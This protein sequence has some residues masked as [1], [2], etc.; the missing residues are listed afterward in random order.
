MISNTMTIL[1][2]CLGVLCL[3]GLIRALRSPVRLLYPS[4]V[5]PTIFFV[6]YG[7]HPLYLRLANNAS[8]YP[9][10][11]ISAVDLE[12]G[13]MFAVASL[14]CFWLPVVAYHSNRFFS[15]IRATRVL[16]CKFGRI[17]NRPGHSL[18][19]AGPINF[20][21]W[22]LVLFFGQLAAFLVFVYAFDGF[23]A[24][25]YAF[26][27]S[28]QAGWT[29]RR[30]G[31]AQHAVAVVCNGVFL[32]G[33]VSA[34]LL[35][36]FEL[37]Q[38][39]K[40]NSLLQASILP[41]LLPRIALLSRGMFLPVV[42]F[43][44]FSILMRGSLDRRRSLALAISIVLLFSG[45][46]LAISRRHITRG[47]LLALRSLPDRY[48]SHEGNTL[49][50]VLY[51][52]SANKTIGWSFEYGHNVT[53]TEG[54]RDCLVLLCPVP[55][56]LI[57]LPF[58]N[59]NEHVG[60]A[61]AGVGIPMPLLG[62]LYIRLGWWGVLFLIPV[63]VA[64]ALIEKGLDSRAA[65]PCARSV[66]TLLYGA[67]LIGGIISLH[68]GIRASTRPLIWVGSAILLVK[69]VLHKQWLPRSSVH[70]LRRAR[71]R[72]RTS[73]RRVGTSLVKPQEYR[74]TDRYLHIH[75]KGRDEKRCCDPVED[76]LGSEETTCG[77]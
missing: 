71:A 33:P 27:D 62:E 67:V 23:R 63:G 14:I 25:L 19:A 51:A 59:L 61:H 37:R 52:M 4:I 50:V 3:P 29:G 6:G 34:G 38:G 35:H 58:S 5:L 42:L 77:M 8:L 40:P 41:S 48:S 44:F 76:A 10:G 75:G 74:S 55:S 69:F 56:F 66:E 24:L 28:Y 64:S 32:L 12:R 15:R 1:S 53:I 21:N 68:A 70:A 18:N 65:K 39:R 36:G 7:L 30:L 26:R 60:V 16:A 31:V 20:R 9:Y 46:S 72:R 2:I 11:K 49:N 17:T 13:Q 54:I 43:W 47:G 45:L 22:E 73:R 57:E